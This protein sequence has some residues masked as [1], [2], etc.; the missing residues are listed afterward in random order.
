MN[1][2]EYERM[3][4]AAESHWWYCGLRDAIVQAV[5]RYSLP[6]HP[7]ECVL[8]AG[9]GSGENL[10]ALQQEL[11]LKYA[12]GFDVSPLALRFAAPKCPEADLYVSDICHPQL[13]VTALDLIVSCDV[14]SVPGLTAA[15]PGL[16]T[17]TAALRPGGLF[18]LNLPAFSWLRSHHDA[19]VHQSHRFDARTVRT[20][21]ETLHLQ[22]ELLTYRVW[23]LF[24]AI[25][26]YRLPT[27]WGRA[28]HDDG[29]S[30]LFV[31]P[32]FWNAALLAI[33]KCEN[34]A[35]ERGVRFPW[36]SSVFAVARKPV[37]C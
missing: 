34:W 9:C 32:L 1:A 6:M 25:V 36:G 8:D 30:D 22:L 24:P 11:P 31:P 12:G 21:M 4:L 3:A 27:L 28:K 14:L 29:P 13:H 15:L 7:T 18:V 10:R 33:L 19:A 35:V 16:Q 2:G 20:L 17:L 37:R 5:R 26:L 23:T